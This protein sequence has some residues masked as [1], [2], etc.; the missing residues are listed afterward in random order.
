MEKLKGSQLKKLQEALH[1]AFPSQ[2]SLRQMVRTELDEHLSRIAGG[3]N[4]SAV[5]FDLIEWAESEGRLQEL[6]EGAHRTNPGNAMLRTFIEKYTAGRDVGSQKQPAAFEYNHPWMFD[7]ETLVNDFIG[8]FLI[9]KQQKQAGLLGFTVPLTEPSPTF[10]KHLCERLSYEC[11]QEGVSIAA[12]HIV[13]SV[14]GIKTTVEQAKSQIIRQCKPTLQR[15]HVLCVVQA[16]DS[17]K[18]L[19][20]WHEIQAGF[21]D[22][23]QH[24]LIVIIGINSGCALEQMSTLQAPCFP[25]HHIMKWTHTIIR[26]QGWRDPEDDLA[27]AAK[28]YMEHIRDSSQRNV[29]LDVDMMYAVL[30]STLREIQEY[31]NCHHFCEEVFG[32]SL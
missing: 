9:Q 16:L 4:L 32:Y 10:L 27:R 12:K 15:R 14:D 29:N 26:S 18:A 30:E 24:L 17:E 21:Q 8:M 22:D 7:L 31:D 3:E 13:V 20:L 28:L 25:D 2:D 11:K 19:S 1:D 5:I 6:I 23:I